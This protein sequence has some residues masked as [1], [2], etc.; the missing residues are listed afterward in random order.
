MANS[1]QQRVLRRQL[2]AADYLGSRGADGIDALRRLVAETEASDGD[3]EA[4]VALPCG[5]ARAI[6]LKGAC[7]NGHVQMLAYLVD[8]CRSDVDLVD[9]ETGDTA[10]HVA[11]SWGRLDCVAWLL[12]RGAR[13]DVRDSAGLTLAGAARRRLEL[14]DR[15]DI[16]AERLRARGMDI[17]AL[18]E[19]GAQLAKLLGAVERAGGWSAFAAKFPQRPR[20]RRAAPWLGAA[21]DRAA[22]AV[23]FANAVRAEKPVKV[24]DVKVTAAQQ[25][26]RANAL[27]KRIAAAEYAA[28]TAAKAS[29]RA[30]DPPLE[31]ALLNA[32]LTSS[33]PGEHN[34]VDPV[35]P[36]ALRWLSATTVDDVRGLEREEVSQVDGPS[37][38]DRRKLWLFCVAQREALEAAVAEATKTAVAEVRELEAVKRA[39]AR[40][41]DPRAAIAFRVPE[42]CFVRVAR[43]LY[44]APRPP[45]TPPPLDAGILGLLEGFVRRPPPPSSG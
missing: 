3:G 44:Y 22:L 35:F 12:A 25:R 8:V 4:L 30:D 2:S 11:V 45:P 32:G 17:D 41:V 29:V 43:F 1:Y 6:P 36:R 10:A 18:R 9:E 28:A 27:T 38:A 15:G 33:A 40:P 20:V 7:M 19:E 34:L 37:S 26:K 13:H 39:A 24:V 21:S 14:L 42:A 16:D 31:V 5:W 23:A